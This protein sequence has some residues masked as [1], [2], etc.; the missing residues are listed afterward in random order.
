MFR[1]VLECS[2]MFHVPGFIDGLWSWVLEYLAIY[3]DL[4]QVDLTSFLASG[5]SFLGGEA[6]KRATKLTLHFNFQKLTVT[7]PIAG[8]GHLSWFL[9]FIKCSG[10]EPLTVVSLKFDL[11]HNLF[12]LGSMLTAIC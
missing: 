1:D 4:L 7:F 3:V 10:V 5:A 6:A 11:L 8:T 2:G 9:F 12:I